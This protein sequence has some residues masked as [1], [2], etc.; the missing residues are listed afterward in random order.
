M[1]R[2][3]DIIDKISEY[4]PEA[5]LDIIDRAYIYSAIVHDGQVRLSGEPYLSHPLEVA[6]LLA[7]MKL[8]VVSIAAGLLHDVIED[9]HATAEEINEMFGQETANIVSGVTKLSVLP[10]DSNS[11]ARQAESIRKMILAMADDIRV[12]MIKLADRLHNMRTLEFHSERK[13]LKIAQET[14]DIYA[15]IAGRLGIY[16]M[17]K[18]LED[19]SFMY[20]QSE[21]YAQ[22]KSLINKDREEGEK[23]IK[24]VK[25]IIKKNLDEHNLK[26]E[27]LGRYKY[28]YSIY[29]KMVSQ[30]LSF[31]EVYDIV[32]FRIIL[33]TIPQC[34]EVLGLI[35]SI[36]KPVAKKFKDYIGVP[37]PNM[38]QSLHTTAIGPF[39]ERIEIQIRTR[40]MD[41]VA[42]SGIAAHW[43]YKEGQGFDEKISQAFSWIQNLVENQEDFIDPDEFLENVRIDLFPDEVYA[44]TPQGDIKSLPRGATPIDFA[45]LIHTEVGNQ[46][47]GAKV[48]GRLVSLQYELKTGDTVEITTSKKGHPSKDWLNFVKTVKARSRIRQWIKIQEK[49]RSITLGREMCEKAF[50]KYRLNFNALL[51]SEEMASVVEGFGFKKIDDLIASVGYGK[52]T[53]LQIIRK[54]APK[55]EPEGDQESIFHK[56]IDRVRKKKP[57]GGVTV[58]G[59]DDIL[60]KFGKCCQPVPGDP[61]TGYI[62]RGFGVTVHRKHC[63]NALKMSSER[64]IDVQWEVDVGETYPVKI[65]IRSYDRVGLLADI[66]SSISKNGANIL[67]ANTETKGRKTVES[68]FA[69]TVEDT[70]HLDRILSAIRKVK[71]IHEAIR[72]DH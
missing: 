47:V 44:F 24:T 27:V 53:P 42:T 72:I 16:W 64:Q 58:K 3:N 30:N 65:R 32:A 23:Y 59:V 70:E 33:D 57:K 15:P 71:H 35:H 36:W 39:G 1:I 52:I 50:R 68:F 5:D 10:F 13:R 40:D 69:I 26:G 34:Y 6:G 14:L 12:I 63:V 18:E 21:E 4:H 25:D 61:I 51:K 43:S 55:P 56:I 46:C 38:Y 9:T 20:L 29:Q 17:K 19:R 62:T 31:E 48:N 49:E 37:K 66:A 45:Y 22:I 11:Q 2:I 28:Y 41:K 67:S 54:I 60:I 7:D 8:D